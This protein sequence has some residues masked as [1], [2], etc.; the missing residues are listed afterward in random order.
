[1]NCSLCNSIIH[2]TNLENQWKDKIGK[3]YFICNNC[4]LIQLDKKQLLSNLE[5]KARYMLHENSVGNKGYI[6]YLNEI[7]GN[8]VKPFLNRGKKILDFGCG[9]EKTLADLLSKEG[10]ILTTFD[11][12]FDTGKEWISQEFDAITAIEVFEHLTYPSRE[13]T[14][15]SKC[16]SPGGYLIIRS[17]LHNKSWINFSKWWYKDDPTHVSFYSMVSINYICKTWNYKLIQVKNQ[18][19]I[20]LKKQ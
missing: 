18:C 16:L 9:P 20:V 4:S 10:Y 15:L 8:S 5:E 7:I 13:L 14:T 6:S 11:P 12:Y 17:M 2:E 3:K 19:E 1:M